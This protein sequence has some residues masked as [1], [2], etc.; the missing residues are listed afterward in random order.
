MSSADNLCR[1]C[2]TESFCGPLGGAGSPILDHFPQVKNHWKKRKGHY[3]MFY[4]ICVAAVGLAVVW[5]HDCVL[6]CVFS[7]LCLCFGTEENRAGVLKKHISV[8][9]LFIS[10]THAYTH[11]SMCLHKTHAHM[12]I[13]K[14]RVACLPTFLLPLGSQSATTIKWEVCDSERA[15]VQGLNG[16]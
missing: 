13:H 7:W 8:L 2:K 6:V 12:P 9:R 10:F 14:Y 4:I 5:P 11:K 3:S 16:A 1:P 15:G